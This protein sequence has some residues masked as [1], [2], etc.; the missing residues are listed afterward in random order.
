MDKENVDYMKMYLKMVNA[1]DD[2][3]NTLIKAMQTC[4]ELYMNH[5]AEE[6]TEERGEEPS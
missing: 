2:A 4:E 6:E 1:A 3:I 5:D